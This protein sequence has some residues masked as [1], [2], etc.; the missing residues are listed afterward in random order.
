MDSRV[1]F[2]R[3]PIF[4]L[5]FILSF[6]FACSTPSWFPFKKELP[7]KAKTKE[8]LD[9]EVILIDKHEYVKVLNPN[10][11]GDASQPKYLYVPVDEYLAKREKY[12]SSLTST[13]SSNTEPRKR[14]SSSASPFLDEPGKEVFV[15]SPKASAAAGLSL[16]KKVLMAPM[17]DRTSGSEEI[18]G[19]WMAEKLMKEA[20]RRSLQILFVDYQMVKEFLDKKG[21]SADEMESPQVLRLL[22]EVFGVHAVVAGQL[23]GPYVFTNKAA[24]DKEE[25]TSA[26]I[27]IELR[28]VDAFSGKT[29]K[30][31]SAN[32][33]AIST[34]EK[35][36]FS[37]E[38]AKGKAI[39]L[40]IA[41]LG[42]SL[43]GGLD[44][45]DW[46]CRVAKVE[47]DQVYVNAGKLTGI[48]AGD[49][50]EIFHPK[51]SGGKEEAI[52][53]IQISAF[54]GLDASIGKITNGKKPEVDDILR[55]AKRD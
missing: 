1:I 35:G 49:V 3:F 7:Y 33:P 6:I 22:N 32:N 53:K 11:S 47:E 5:L 26:I 14:V 13:A 31:L 52:G 10:S 16:K 12:A 44:S 21:I 23:T 18:L 43:S 54:F 39:D 9:K 36:A 17:D 30:T 19:D 46:F 40:T 42:R 45:V 4:I 41:E 51:E 37:E 24:N 25:T 29:L 15:A 27:K 50:L 20:T 48:K 38:K 34:K 28:I 2:F 55:V 8:L